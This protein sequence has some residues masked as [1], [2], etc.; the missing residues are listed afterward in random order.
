[1][2][3]ARNARPC[4][5]RHIWTAGKN[6]KTKCSVRSSTLEVLNWSCTA[7]QC[8]SPLCYFFSTFFAWT[9]NAAVKIGNSSGAIWKRWTQMFI[10]RYK[11][12]Q[13]H[14]IEMYFELSLLVQCSFPV[15]VFLHKVKVIFFLVLQAHERQAPQTG[16]RFFLWWKGPSMRGYGLSFAGSF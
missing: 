14:G 4:P 10:T 9:D 5:S 13:E 16:R 2:L 7:L 11:L 6:G 3:P 12:E 1:M 8:Q 15:F